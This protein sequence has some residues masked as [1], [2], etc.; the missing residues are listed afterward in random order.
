MAQ[1]DALQG[2]LNLLVLKLLARRAPL[3]GYAIMA[4]IQEL[5]ADVLR[6]EQGSLYPALHRMEEDGWIR[7]EWVAR[8]N[9]KRVRAYS[10]TK[11]GKVQLEKSEERWCAVTAAVNRLLEFA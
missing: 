10:L 6:V 1:S 2:S 8:E 5:T 7:A 3:H 9:G 4:A 11:A